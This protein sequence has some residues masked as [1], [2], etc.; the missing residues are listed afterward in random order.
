MDPEEM[1]QHSQL[2]AQS[3]LDSADFMKDTSLNDEMFL[4]TLS[5]HMLVGGLA[6]EDEDELEDDADLERLLANRNC[7]KPPRST[8]AV[9]SPTGK[10]PDLGHQRR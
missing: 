2:T 1:M 9:F 5:S 10:A 7:P 8:G 3:Q 6:E 4:D